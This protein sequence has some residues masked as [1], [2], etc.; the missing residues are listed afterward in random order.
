[1]RNE[2]EMKKKKIITFDGKSEKIQKYFDVR[3]ICNW[4]N[5]RCVCIHIAHRGCTMRESINWVTG[6]RFN[7]AMQA[8]AIILKELRIFSKETHHILRLSHHHRVF[9]FILMRV[10]DVSMHNIVLGVACN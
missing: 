2:T 10:I 1:M 3:I 7:F 6:H 4:Y 9:Y 8:K 5:W